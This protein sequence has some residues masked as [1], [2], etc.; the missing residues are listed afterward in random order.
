MDLYIH[1]IYEYL[2]ENDVG[3]PTYSLS[4]SQINEMIRIKI[5]FNQQYLIRLNQ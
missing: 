3:D 2:L 1:E 4:H 5:V